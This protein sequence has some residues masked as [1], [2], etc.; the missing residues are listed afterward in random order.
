MRIWSSP[1]WASRRCSLG[2][3]APCTGQGG[4]S[5]SLDATVTRRPKIAELAVPDKA[6]IP[7]GTSSKGSTTPIIC[8]VVDF[9]S[10]TPGSFIDALVFLGLHCR[11][12]MKTETL[13]VL[14]N[15]IAV[16]RFHPNEEVRERIRA[17]LGITGDQ[18]VYLLLGWD[19]HTKGV[20]L[21]VKAAHGVTGSGARPS[22][23]LIIGEA[24][25]REF[26]I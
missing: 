15:G 3:Q 12:R 24:R 1:Y 2:G 25:T 20:D 8:H 10:K 23:F 4:S 13:F 16:N 22:L 19:P 26:L 5:R 6:V 17:S 9:S 14:D 18:T 11:E 21:F 7:N